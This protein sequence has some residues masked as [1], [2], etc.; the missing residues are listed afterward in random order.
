MSDFIHKNHTIYLE[1]LTLHSHDYKRVKW[2]SVESQFLRFK[3][4]C[5]IASDIFTS[6]LLDVGCG[7]GHLADHLISKQFVGVY[8]G[9]DLVEQMIEGARKRHPFFDFETNDIDAI[10]KESYDYVLASG[11]FAFA[12]WENMQETIRALFC[13]ATKGVAFN[14][15][16]ALSKHKENES[17]LFYPAPYEVLAFCQS[18]TSKIALR[19]DYLENDFT[20]Y[21]YK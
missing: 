18:I 13:R 11:I 3:I 19:H 5:E 21:L 2:N 12:D 10:A 17:E 7:L 8:K 14:C 15:L 20:L 1:S 4:L 6:S 9:I 16:S